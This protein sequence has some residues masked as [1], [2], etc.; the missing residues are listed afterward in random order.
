ME[1]RNLK[2]LETAIVKLFLLSTPVNMRKWTRTLLTTCMEKF[3]E[4]E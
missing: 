1:F 3:R 4:K 2:T